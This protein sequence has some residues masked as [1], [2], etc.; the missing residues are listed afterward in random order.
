MKR[1]FTLI[2]SVFV[3][4]T[5]AQTYTWTNADNDNDFE[6]PN[7]W[8]PMPMFGFPSAGESVIFDGTVS[9]AN[10]NLPNDNTLN[11]ISML[12][13]YTGVVNASAI[14]LD[15]VN[16]NLAGGTLSAPSGTLKSTH[17]TLQ[18]VGSGVFTNNGGTVEHEI[19]NTTV[20]NVNGTFN[21]N[22][23]ALTV[24]GSGNRTINFNGSSTCANLS[25][26]NAATN[27]SIRGTVNV[28]GNLVL[29]G[30]S[31]S[32]A[33]NNTG[34]IVFTGA[35]NHTI[36]GTGSALQSPIGRI[37][38]NTTGSL[39]MSGNLTL[40][41]NT[42]GGI[43]TTTNLGGINANNSTVTFG[44]TSTVTAGNSST[45][46]ACFD[47][48]SIP[49]G[50]T[51]ILSGSSQVNVTGNITNDGTL[52]SNT[53][54]IRLTGSTQ[55]LSGTSTT[56]LNALE[57]VTGGNKT[58]SSPL[59]I[60][61]SIKV[62]VGTLA[63][64]GN[65]RLISTSSLKGRIA[66]IT[67]GGS[68]SGNVTVETFALGGTTDWAVLGGSGVNG[69]SFNSW[70]GQIPMAIEG[71]ATD[72]TS[73]GGNYFESVQGWNEAD[74]YGYD[75]TIVVGSSIVSG[76]G[77]WVYLG[78]ALGS[79]GA[80]TYNVTGSVVQGNVSI[81]L[82]NSAQ[83]GFN[84][85]AN[86]YASPISWTRLRNGNASVANA[87]Y[88][89]NADIG[90]TT[91]F[92]GGVSSHGP[93]VGAQDDIPMGQ[94]FYVQATANT[95]LTAQESNKVSNNTGAD[96]LLKTAKVNQS[97]VGE[98][99]WLNFTGANDYDKT[100]IRFHSG[101][102]NLFD[103]EADAHKFYSSPGYIGY[104][105]VWT[106]RTAIA[107]KL[108]NEEYSINSV[109]P[110]TSSPIVMDVI[111]RPYQSGVYTIS[112]EG[113]EN[114]TS[115]NCLMLRDK[116]TNT[117]HDLRS[118]D[119]TF[120]ISDTTIA[121]R[122]ELTVCGTNYVANVASVN[123]ENL[124]TIGQDKNAAYVNL[125]F[126]NVTDATISVTDI[127]GRK[128]ISDIKVRT[129]K[130]TVKLDLPVN[131]EVLMITVTTNEDRITKKLVR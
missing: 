69:L 29:G 5:N 109:N 44:N 27:L 70:Y 97:N 91:S 106:K 130:E 67:G 37:T 79:T 119:Y 64:G 40:A 103:L 32:A 28:T 20:R 125:S 23:Y 108:G 90:T 112:A 102:S 87:I 80:I 76:K 100:A 84:L 53:G 71:S 121:A 1:I 56:T 39:T 117:I 105:G 2:A 41:Q 38:F 81:P 13:S 55:A 114:V 8:N 63:A 24:T 31:T 75:T 45:T 110:H 74:A 14:N 17:G 126:P 68:I 118:G 54:L 10:C 99:F 107:T 49:T 48:I 72:Q 66:E 128:V 30:T 57:V 88:I 116:V 124:V 43:W 104:P 16:L 92:A 42:N 26:N 36:T 131:N 52:T 18:Q 4:G 51:M 101:A 122:F 19:I 82:T 25:F 15:I 89:Y 59:R 47:N 111:T 129:D 96:Q 86:P 11:L 113:L 35:G 95:N 46:R 62:G 115:Q 9:N 65:V 98:V 123:A 77:Y 3:M 61:D 22:N 127:L 7:N 50:S 6:N 34:T 73:T 93:G 78:D 33:P 60:L 12:A 21:F 85:I 83:T 58:I 94:G 120:N